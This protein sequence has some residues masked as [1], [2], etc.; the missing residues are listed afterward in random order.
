MPSRR[1]RACAR[2][3]REAVAQRYVT[4][5]RD[6]HQAEPGAAGIRLAHPLVNLPERFLH[7]RECVMAVLHGRLEEFLGEL[8]ELAEQRVE[9]LVG[10]RVVVLRRRRGRCEADLL[11]A[12]VLGEVAEDPLHVERARRQRDPRAN[13]P[14]AGACEISSLIFG[15]TTS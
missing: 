12:D 4:V 5:G 10:D 1:C 15:A 9:P 11:E 14:R 6:P 7:V 2:R 13:R 8:A 3:T